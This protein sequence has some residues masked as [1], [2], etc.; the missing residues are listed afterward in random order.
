[1]LDGKILITENGQLILIEKLIS[2]GPFAPEGVINTKDFF[3]AYA[4][5]EEFEEGLNIFRL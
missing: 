3:S 2:L 1:M 5:L 4:Q